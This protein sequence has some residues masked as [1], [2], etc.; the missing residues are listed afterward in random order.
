[1]YSLMD[2]LASVVTDAASVKAVDKIAN[3]VVASAGSHAVDEKKA[4]NLRGKSNAGPCYR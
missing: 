4:P 3:Q 2:D 1:M